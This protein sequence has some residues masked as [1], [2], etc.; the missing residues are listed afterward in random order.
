MKRC[1]RC[2]N[3]K[4]KEEFSRNSTRKD[5]L[6]NQCKVCQSSTNAAYRASSRDKI[7]ASNAE[8]RAANRE[9]IAARSAAYHAANRERI[10][11]RNA[12]LRA[13]NKERIAAR[14][15][16]Y[17]AANRELILAKQAAYKAANPEKVAASKEAYKA[18]NPDKCNAA[19]RAWQIKNPEKRA[20]NK[21]NR[22]ARTRNSDGSHTAADVRAIFDNQGG[23]CA[24]CHAKLFKSGKQKFHVDHI[25]P[26]ALSGSNR[27]ENLQCLCPP[28]NLSKGAKHPIDFAQS[29][30]KLL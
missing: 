11:A 16:A 10:L 17:Y 24:N 26:L 22:R 3:D 7:A 5:G 20:A 18:A 25:M 21:R 15:A 23:L 2:L 13:E 29:M 4:P 27:P 1:A 6:Q 14:G 30:G 19:K 9:R 28:C 12:A 8:Y